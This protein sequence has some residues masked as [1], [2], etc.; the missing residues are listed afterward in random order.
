M[1]AETIDRIL[2]E[3]PHRE[4]YDM[5]RTNLRRYVCVSCLVLVEPTRTKK[6]NVNTWKAFRTPGGIDAEHPYVQLASFR[7]AHEIGKSDLEDST[8]GEALD[9]EI[10][11]EYA[12]EIDA[13]DAEADS[14]QEAS[15]RLQV[16]R[17]FFSR[18]F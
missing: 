12:E 8:Q 10:L 4:K 2:L 3:S 15:D 18:H 14:D 6:I 11:R 5:Q 1:T 7:I 13:S 17:N 16:C 9:E